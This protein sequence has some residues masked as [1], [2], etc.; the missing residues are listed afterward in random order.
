MSERAPTSPWRI[1]LIREIT[2]ILLIKLTLLLGIKAIWFTEPT[3]PKDGQ[4]R[5]ELHLFGQPASP[6][7]LPTEEKPR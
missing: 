3:V 5:V 4:Q 6:S 7:S 2:V 1:P